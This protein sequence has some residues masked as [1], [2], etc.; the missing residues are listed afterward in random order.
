VTAALCAGRPPEFWWTGHQGNRLA[1][2]I[3]RR[4]TACPDNDP[5]PHGVIR[6]GVAYSDA[7]KPLPLCSACGGPN[8]GYNGGDPSLKVCAGCAVPDLPLPKWR[9]SRNRWLVGLVARGFT[10]R[11]AGAQAGL[12]RS[13]VEK[14]LVRSRREVAA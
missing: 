2:A 3:C 4:C 5:E 9:A 6:R 7:G 8:V 13:A 14:V 12:T 1:L 11:Q 10:A